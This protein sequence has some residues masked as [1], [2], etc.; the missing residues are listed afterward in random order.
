DGVSTILYSQ[1]FRTPEEIAESSFQELERIPGF[2]KN[3]LEE[4]QKAAKEYVEKKR[5]GLIVEEEEPEAPAVEV[6]PAVEPPSGEAEP[7]SGDTPL[8]DPPLTSPHGGEKV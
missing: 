1:A 3:R 7:P 4:I 2:S 6:A 8:S 5:Q